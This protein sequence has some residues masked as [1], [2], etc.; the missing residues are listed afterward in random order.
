MR[1]IRELGRLPGRGCGS[2]CFRASTATSATV[3][4]DRGRSWPKSATVVSRSAILVVVSPRLRRIRRCRC[5]SRSAIL[6][7]VSLYALHR[8]QFANLA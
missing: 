3:V 2:L 1:C 4:A 6:V 8:T 7:M 5:R